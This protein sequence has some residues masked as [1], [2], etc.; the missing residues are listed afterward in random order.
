MAN[1]VWDAERQKRTGVAEAV[2]CSGKSAQDLADIVT[3]NI[4][5]S[6]PLLMT[7]LTQAQWQSLPISLQQ[8]LSYD[9]V[10]QTACANTPNITQEPQ[11]VCIVCAG[12]SDLSVAR[13]AQRTLEFNGL[14]APLIADVGV[15]GLWRLMDRIEEIRRYKIIIA[16][17]GMEGAL[18]S[19]LAGLV[20]APVIAVPSAVGYGV[21]ENGQAALTSALS[22]CAPGVLTVNINNGFG[23]AVAAIKTLRQFE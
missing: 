20:S 16:V 23:A 12:T 2:F 13:E 10:S 5:H 7:R 3:H 14:A 1:F 19:V 21:S 6:L 8:Q 11:H 22:S 4:A 18:F 15:A 17:A 9:Q